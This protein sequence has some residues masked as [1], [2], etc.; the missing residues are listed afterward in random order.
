MVDP[1]SIAIMSA[2]ANLSQEVIKDAYNALKASLQH[3]F[4]VKSDL[5]EAVDKLEQKPSEGRAKTL[6]EEVAASGAD[7][8]PELRQIAEALIEQ[9]KQLPGGTANIKQN[10][11]IHGNRN[12]VT[13]QGD[14]TVNE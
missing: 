7:K 1:I 3:K 8:D 2:L 11:Q 14:V 5:V 12:I 9:L 6:Q 4:G 13:G 10:I